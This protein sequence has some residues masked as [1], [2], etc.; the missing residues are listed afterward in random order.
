MLFEFISRDEDENEFY[1]VVLTNSWIRMTT[2]RAN[3]RSP[4][5]QMMMMMM[6]TTNNIVCVC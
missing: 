1:V 6:T 3:E 5:L 4:Q 2:L